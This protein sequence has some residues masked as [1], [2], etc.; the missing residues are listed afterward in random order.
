MSPSKSSSKNARPRSGPLTK[1]A[2]HRSITQARLSTTSYFQPSQA[3]EVSEN[4][5]PSDRPM[6]AEYV[7]E[8]DIEVQDEVQSEG[9]GDSED[10][11]DSGDSEDE[12]PDGME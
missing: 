8:D 2:N 10:D 3:D 4:L 9:N 1:P 7:L 11:L 6:N 12:N 5:N